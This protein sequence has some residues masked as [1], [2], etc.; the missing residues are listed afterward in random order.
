MWPAAGHCANDLSGHAV[1]DGGPLDLN[2]PF[3]FFC[4]YSRSDRKEAYNRDPKRIRKVRFRCGLMFDLQCQLPLS[5]IWIDHRD[6]HIS[7]KISLFY[8]KPLRFQIA[9]ISS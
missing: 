4:C 1:K 3:F 8:L 2:S 9:A 6:G 7:A 5:L